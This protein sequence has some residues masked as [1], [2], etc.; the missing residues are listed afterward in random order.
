MKRLT[1]RIKKNVKSAFIIEEIKSL[2]KKLLTNTQTYS[3]GMQ[4]IIQ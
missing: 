4:K 3:N 2:I 1:L